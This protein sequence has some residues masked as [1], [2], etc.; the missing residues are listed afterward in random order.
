MKSK[1]I[2]RR[3]HLI[4][5]IMTQE[6]VVVEKVLS[7]DNIINLLTKLLFQ[8]IFKHHKGLMGIKDIDD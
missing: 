5:E 7:E 6:D 8:I 4:R 3:F 1:H 2:L